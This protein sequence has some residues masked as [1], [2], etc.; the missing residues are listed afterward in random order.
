[1]FVTQ[2]DPCFLVF[3]ITIHQCR[4]SSIGLSKKCGA[5]LHGLA[6]QDTERDLLKHSQ[7]SVAAVDRWLEVKQEDLSGVSTVLPPPPS[8][9]AHKNPSMSVATSEETWHH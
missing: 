2:F 5:D 4:C 1:M 6:L 9:F 7:G 3:I 8:S